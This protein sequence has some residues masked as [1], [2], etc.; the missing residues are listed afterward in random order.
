MRLIRYGEPGYEKPGLL[1]QGKRKDCSN[2]FK[3]WDHYFFQND[4]LRGLSYFLKT[5][6]HLED[7]AESA[8]WA[9]CVARPG[10]IIGIG[11]NYKDHAREI[12]SPLPKEPIIFLKASN[13]ISGPYDN[14]VIPKNSKKTDWEIELGIVVEK[15]VRYLQSPEEAKK[16]IAG[17]T[18]SHDISEREFQ[19]E[20]GGQWSKGKS[21]DTFNPLGPFLATADEIPQAKNL[22]LELKVNGEVRQSGNTSDMIFDAEF[23]VYYISQFM[24]LEAGDVISSGTP[25]G[26][27]LGMKPPAFL[28]AG[29]WVELAITG[30]GNQRQKCVNYI[31]Y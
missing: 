28:Q 31:Q 9:S 15:T 25:A 16:Y 26:V 11:L 3:D 17:Y 4:G 10:K 6:P 7:I 12:N 24:T 20:R 29:D 13:C 18:I 5:N 2:Y 8:R 30:L 14:I 21:C 1:I 22:G 19:L 27:G 23:L